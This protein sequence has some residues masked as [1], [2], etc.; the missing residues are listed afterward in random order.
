[1]SIKRI[2]LTTFSLFFIMSFSYAETLKL[3]HVTP[4]SHIW[5]KTA[6]RFAQNLQKIS[7]NKFNI[8]IYP[9]SKLGGD[10]QMVDLLQSGAIQFA[11]L[12]GAS[13]S[14]R[15]PSMNSWFL[16]YVFSNMEESIEATKTPEAQALLKDLEKQKL[17]GLGYSMVGMRILISTMPINNLAVLHNQKIR[18]YPNP[19]FNSWWNE[20]DAAP[21]ALSV[22]DML[23]AL[24]TNLISGVDADLDIVVGM[25]MYQQAPYITLFNHMTFPGVIVASKPWWD[26]LNQEEQRQIKE[27]FKEAEA[28][29]F[30]QQ[31]QQEKNNIEIL[32]KAGVSISTP[33]YEP[34]NIIGKKVAEKYASTD[35]LMKKFYDRFKKSE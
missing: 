10:E 20:L 33:N 11:V 5:H 31:T 16:P 22:S 3:G 18:S 1:M 23:P 2:L 26:K 21:T 15:S 4:P 34:L 35:P 27:A 13:L 14:N 32:K 29:G 24:T 28:W 7:N 17:V 25:K 6:V 8:K 30:N 19:L 12:T 9:L